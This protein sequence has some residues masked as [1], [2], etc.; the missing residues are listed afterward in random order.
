VSG[1]EQETHVDAV[2]TIPGAE[3]WSARGEGE[4]AK[5]GVVVVHGFTA[6]PLGTRPLGQRIAAEGYTVEV[7]CLPGHGTTIRDFGRSRYADWYRALEHTVDHLAPGCDRIVLVGHS[8]G[9]TL[10]LDLAS[11][12][13]AGIAG[14]VAINA[15]VSQ[16]VQPLA[17]V[18]PILQYLLPYVP[19]DLGGLPGND[20]AK[21]GVEE[22][23]YAFVSAKAAQSLIVELPRIRQQLPSLTAPLLVAWS[24]QDHSVPPENS[25][26]LQELAGSEDVTE[27]RCERSYHVAQLDYDA[28]MLGQAIVGFIGRVTGT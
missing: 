12:R 18:A 10:S 23:A 6:N 1:D 9:G 22:G 4:R 2:V 15:Q 20:I 26:V 14:V 3:P 24:P 16:P 7:P 11:R 19:R 8:M 13:P 27:V 17:K 25:V 21:P 5:V 28:E